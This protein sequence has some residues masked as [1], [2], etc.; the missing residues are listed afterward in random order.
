MI[1]LGLGRALIGRLGDLR[2]VFLGRR[3]CD[4]AL[5]DL[6][7]GLLL[8]AEQGNGRFLLGQFV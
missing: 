1:E 4:A 6:L 8:P 7:F 5:F 2:G 3:L